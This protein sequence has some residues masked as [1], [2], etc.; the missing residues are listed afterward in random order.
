M[1]KKQ[2]AR[3]KELLAIAEDDRSE[4][5]A[6]ELNKLFA[7]AT[8]KGVDLSKEDAPENA[9]E[10]GLSED[11]VSK[12]VSDGVA[13]GL[14]ALGI[15]DGTIK[16]IQESLDKAGSGISKEDI[17]AALTEHL[18]ENSNLDPDAL[19]ALVEESAKK[20]VGGV[21]TKE[22]LDEALK[23]FKDDL[24]KTASKH[25]FPGN[26]QA[27]FPVEHRS[28]N[29][30]VG[31]KQLL[32]L[33]VGSVSDEAIEKSG[34]H[35]PTGIN[36]GI[37]PEVLKTAQEC[38]KRHLT[39]M[40]EEIRYGKALTSTGSNAG[41]ELVPTDLSSDLQLRLYL[42]SQLAS[43]MISSEIEMPTNP[44]NFPLVTTRPTFYAG[45]ENPGSDPTESSPATA[46]LTFSAAK[47]IGMTNFSYE[48]DE[49]AILSILPMVTEQLGAGA[50]D[51][52]ESAIISGD[53]DG[54][55]QD[56]DYHAVTSHHATLFNGM[57]KLA[58]AIASLKIDLS[59]GGVSAANILTMK[60][61]LGKW[62][63]RPQDLL[64]VFGVGGYNDAIGLSETLTA[65]KVGSN[66]ARIL[67][68]EAPS[69]Y[70]TRIVVSSQMRENV[71][72][73]GVYDGTTTTKGTFIMFHKPSWMLGV[74]RGF[75][76]EV[77]VDKK[78]QINS[79][80]ASFRRDLKPKETPAATTAQNVVIG[81]NYTA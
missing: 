16:G 12:L 70:G 30:S 15:E 65:E 71:N 11:E 81:Y 64:I 13:S 27:R 62:G 38:G 47:L 1:N 33:M 48:A 54:T 39:K 34:G 59:S 77:D 76:V 18:G 32:N 41:D 8:E 67:T 49:D 43:E 69:I 9:P 52:L 45:S 25:V 66:V 46:Q 17:Q 24:Q 79:V 57:R 23:G 31:Q 42:E 5:Q 61:A 58:L 73:S 2:I 20:A 60:K 72:A 29:L 35:R 40:R 68:G 63:V 75:L 10:G 4:A 36:D 7:L 74:K 44:F 55:H 22:Q 6:K 19:K 80:I 78:R 53:S 26:D 3:A 56:S 50:A 28:G 51:A 14:K 37:E 21:I